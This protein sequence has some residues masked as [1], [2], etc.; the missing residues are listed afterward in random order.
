MRGCNSRGPD[1]VSRDHRPAFGVSGAMQ[2]KDPISELVAEL[3]KAVIGAELHRG[4]E[5][6]KTR[7]K[8][9]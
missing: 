3:R 6:P 9:R 2:T 5:A 7:R 8:R 1:A 4:R